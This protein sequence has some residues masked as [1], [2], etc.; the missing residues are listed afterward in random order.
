MYDKKETISK[1]PV[2]R[3]KITTRDFKPNWKE[4]LISMGKMGCSDVEMR[5]ELGISDDTWYRMMK[6]DEVFSGTVKEARG[7]CRAWW[8][9]HGRK[10]L[11]NKD[12]SPT[13]W[14]MN[15]KNRFGWADKRGI[16]HTSKG[17]KIEGFTYV[18]P[19]ESEDV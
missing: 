3:P 8:E 16:D 1:R 2:G 18:V 12:F 9:A 7:F 15:M 10:Q 5:C 19:K 6:E 4:K 17:E 13:L 11:E 14:Y